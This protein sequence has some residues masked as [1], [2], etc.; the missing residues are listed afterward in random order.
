VN[1]TEFFGITFDS[2][3]WI[4]SRRAGFLQRLRNIGRLGKEI[5]SRCTTFF[6]A[7]LIRLEPA[8]ENELDL[9]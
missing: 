3:E 1:Q 7:A 5:P 6:L 9:S 4:E 8:Q 2:R